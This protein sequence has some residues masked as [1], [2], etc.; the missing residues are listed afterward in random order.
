M[1]KGLRRLPKNSGDQGSSNSTW[2]DDSH[3][4]IS[5]AMGSEEYK[6]FL[7][8]NK[9]D[10]KTDYSEVNRFDRTKTQKDRIQDRHDK[11]TD[12]DEHERE[13]SFNEAHPVIM[14]QVGD[15]YQKKAKD[16]LYQ[17]KAYAHIKKEDQDKKTTNRAMKEAEKTETEADDKTIKRNMPKTLEN[18]KYND[19]VT[20][21]DY[22]PKALRK[23]GV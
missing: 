2:Q 3:E 4:Q 11:A 19:G 12:H 23:Y 22:M 1:A 18:L 13:R 21:D 8:D 15:G 16:K 10:D 9:M 5:L 7:H 6:E 17:R 14:R 20:E